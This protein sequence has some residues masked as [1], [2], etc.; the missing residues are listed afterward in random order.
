[1]NSS[2]LPRIQ[3]ILARQSPA[4]DGGRSLFRQFDSLQLVDLVMN[5]EKEFQVRINSFEVTPDNFESAEALCQLIEKK[6]SA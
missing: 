2:L 3:A 4:L 5:L 6:R 1:M